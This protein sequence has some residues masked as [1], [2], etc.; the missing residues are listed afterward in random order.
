MN[1]L[2]IGWPWFFKQIFE[3]DTTSCNTVM[4]ACADIGMR[5]DRSIGCPWCEK[6]FSAKMVVYNLLVYSSLVERV[7]PHQTAVVCWFSML[8]QCWLKVVCVFWCGHCSVEARNSKQMV[9]Q[10]IFGARLRRAIA[11]FHRKYRVLGDKSR[12]HEVS[13]N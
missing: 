1:K 12:C 13:N 11:R 7:T 5:P 4:K 9:H 6:P 3:A 10:K 8:V 2:L